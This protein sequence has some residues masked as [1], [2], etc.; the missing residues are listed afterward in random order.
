MQWR[1]MHELASAAEEVAQAAAVN[2]LLPSRA[3]PLRSLFADTLHVLPS[4]WKMLLARVEKL[5]HRDN[6]Y[7]SRLEKMTEAPRF[8][9]GFTEVKVIDEAGPRVYRY[10]FRPLDV[11]EMMVMHRLAHD[12]SARRIFINDLVE[13]LAATPVRDDKTGRIVTF[14]EYVESS[15]KDWDKVAK[16]VSEMADEVLDKIKQWM[17]VYDNGGRGNIRVEGDRLAYYLRVRDM[18]SRMR[19]AGVVTYASDLVA[20]TMLMSILARSRLASLNPRR[21]EYTKYWRLF[22]DEDVM[23]MYSA[24]KL[25]G[26]AAA[27]ANDHESL[28]KARE[29]L[30]AEFEKVLAHL[31]VRERVVDAMKPR[32]H[33]LVEEAMR[34]AASP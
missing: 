20:Y 22:T 21:H 10:E 34:L 31:E 12:P 5:F 13:A 2:A 33:K 4:S 26:L 28:R 25:A 1:R 7:R 24:D 19:G 27:A 32:R 15:G 29:E 8:A 6:W 11:L 23:A 14:K 3:R 16:R 17:E 18:A 9:P 30:A